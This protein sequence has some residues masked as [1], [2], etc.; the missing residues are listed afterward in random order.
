MGKLFEE[1]TCTADGG[2]AD[3]GLSVEREVRI[4]ASRH[5]SDPDKQDFRICG[6]IYR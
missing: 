5:P 6:L 1:L 4:S 2:G 3:F